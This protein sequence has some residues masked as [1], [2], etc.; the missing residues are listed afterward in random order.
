M[1]ENIE[2]KMKAGT[3]I[4]KTE[5]R[6]NLWL[7]MLG[8]LVLAVCVRLVLAST[9]KPRIY[10]PHQ[11]ALNYTTYYLMDRIEEA[12]SFVADFSAEGTRR[13][14]KEAIEAAKRTL[15]ERH[16]LLERKLGPVEIRENETFDEATRAVIPCLSIKLRNQSTG[17]VIVVPDQR[18]DD[19]LLEKQ[20]TTEGKRWRIIYTGDPSYAE[21][22]S[23]W[24][25]LP[26]K[27]VAGSPTIILKRAV[28]IQVVSDGKVVSERTVFCDQWGSHEDRDEKENEPSSKENIEKNGTQREFG[29]M[30]K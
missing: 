11:I 17:K 28:V 25:N 20:E 26:R 22:E 10:P 12:F 4:K 21:I 18:V 27:K 8:A 2:G 19:W 16:Q 29:I 5:S 24:L 1:T 9:K 15:I 23:T 30:L 3:G 14:K 7:Y 13:G 6:R